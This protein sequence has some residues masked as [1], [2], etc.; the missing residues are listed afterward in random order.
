MNSF[1]KQISKKKFVEVEVEGVK[2]KFLKPTFGE[3]LE[4]QENMQ[5]FVGKDSEPEKLL[6]LV[7]YIL[8]NYGYTL[9]E[10]PITEDEEN[11]IESLKN[12]TT[13]FLQALIE[14][15]LAVVKPDEK[16]KKTKRLR[17]HL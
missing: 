11:L 2:L 10:K 3:A 14:A 9:E 5:K 17:K 13:D 1:F 12:T 4:M 8:E 15:F 6:E 16:T 7:A